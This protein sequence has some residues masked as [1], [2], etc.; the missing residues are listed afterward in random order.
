MSINYFYN[1]D[2]FGKQNKYPCHRKADAYSHRTDVES[3]FNRQNDCFI[4]LN[5]LAKINVKF[6]VKLTEGRFNHLKQTLTVLKM[7]NAQ[8]LSIMRILP[9]RETRYKVN[10]RIFK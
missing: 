9:K 2:V 6:S 8:W 1:L 10:T 3:Q 5:I 7:F 4:G